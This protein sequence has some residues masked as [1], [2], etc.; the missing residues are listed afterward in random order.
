MGT[1][2]VMMGKSASGKDTIYH[3]VMSM[4]PEL[5]KVI[6]YT[7]RPIRAGEEDGREYIFS[8]IKELGQL[9]SAGKVVECR[10][11][12][13][14]HGTWYYFTVDDGAIDLEI[15]DYLMISTLEGYEKIRDYY[16]EQRVQP[17]YIAVNDFERMERSL[18]R[19]RQQENPCVAE[20]C[21]RFLAD[22]Q[23]FSREKLARAG[24]FEEI[25]NDNL[26]DCI[27]RVLKRLDKSR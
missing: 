4:C 9:R 16:G 14:V 22:E 11:Y 12:Q 23:D 24:V 10:E 27:C 7:T 25:E 19:E 8:N 18:K 3:R 15:Y 20:V 1:L 13:T 26:E 21:R 5:K 17:I 2:Y 6:P